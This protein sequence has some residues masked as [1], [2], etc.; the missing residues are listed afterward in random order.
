MATGVG[1]SRICL[2]SFNSPTPKTPVRR[3]HLADISYT[4]RVIA[5][6]VPNFV[7]TAT[8]VGRSRIEF[9]WHHSIA[10]PPKPPVSRKHL[11]GISYTSRV[12]A[13][14]VPNFVAIATGVIRG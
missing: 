9:V 8:G 6:F 10:R 11:A 13:D 1:R 12:I 4:S 14:F 5:D 3:K 2:A 7:A